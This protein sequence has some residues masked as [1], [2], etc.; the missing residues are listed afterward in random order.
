GPLKSERSGIAEAMANL[1]LP[2]SIQTSPA[3]G[4]PTESA[5]AHVGIMPIAGERHVGNLFAAFEKHAPEL[6][7]LATAFSA[8]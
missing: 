2:P 3:L 6:R 5:I 7:N 1:R 8:A 4:T